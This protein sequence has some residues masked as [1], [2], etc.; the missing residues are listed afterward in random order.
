M[1]TVG[2][3]ALVAALGL[4]MYADGGE[5]PSAD[6]RPLVIEAAYTGDVWRNVRGGLRQ[7][8]T[9]L[10][11]IDVVATLDAER[12]FGWSGTT[13]L[14]SGLYNNRSTLSD[15]IVGDIQAVSNIDTDGAARLYEAWVERAFSRGALKLGLIDLSSEFDVNE[16]GMLFVNSSHGTGPD[17]SQVGENGPAIFPITGLG[18]LTRLHFGERTQVRVAAFEATVGDPNHPRR[19]TLDLESDEGALLVAELTFRPSEASRSML[20]VWRH[21][22]RTTDLADPH[23]KHRGESIG[24]YALAEG[25]LLHAGEHALNGFVRLGFAD[26]HVHQIA[27][28]Q[29]AGVVWSGPLFAGSERL[30][31][32]GLAVGVVTNGNTFRRVQAELGSPAERQET[33]IELT[34]RVQALPWLALQP[35]VQYIV[36]PGTDPTL[37]NAW[38]LG[39]RFE[40]SWSSEPG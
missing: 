21:N 35:D 22:G 17:F 10:D 5:M 12:A 8:D 7:D 19:T 2:V 14:L 34:Y 25:T 16:T 29:G 1:R 24:L 4:P 18:L 11:N 30:E 27:Q 3:P 23:S 40:L 38:V 31:R 9:Y 39:L 36:N 28:Y 20:G 26:A 6:S 13:I 37:D 15:R 32:L 33:A